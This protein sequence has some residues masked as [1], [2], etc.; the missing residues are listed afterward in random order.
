MGSDWAKVWMISSLFVL[1]SRRHPEGS[2]LCGVCKQLH[3]WEGPQHAQTQIPTDKSL[4][5]SNP[6]VVKPRTQNLIK[7]STNFRTIQNYCIKS[8]YQIRSFVTNSGR[9]HCPLQSFFLRISTLEHPQHHSRKTVLLVIIS[10]ITLWHGVCVPS[11][12]LNILHMWEWDIKKVLM[13]LKMHHMF[14]LNKLKSGV[15]RSFSYQEDFWQ[16]KLTKI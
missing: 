9:M 5:V 7:N 2:Q 10:H 4:G 16:A 11:L 1:L 15:E 14:L 13:H 12:T 8:N 6:S 3:S